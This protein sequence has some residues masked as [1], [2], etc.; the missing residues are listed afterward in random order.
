MEAITSSTKGHK[1]QDKDVSSVCPPKSKVNSVRK[2]KSVLISKFPDKTALFKTEGT[3]R[4]NDMEMDTQNCSG[5]NGKGT[6]DGGSDDSDD[7]SQ[8]SPIKLGGKDTKNTDDCSQDHMSEIKYAGTETSGNDDLSLYRAIELEDGRDN[9]DDFSQYSAIELEDEVTDTSSDESDDLLHYKAIEL[10][11][12]ST[13]TTGGGGIDDDD[14]I[15][16]FSQFRAIELEDDI[17]ETGDEDDDLS[18]YKPIELEDKVT[19]R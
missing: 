1:V 9:D 8:Y 4:D 18:H 10:E 6:D 2:Q 13:K 12:N 17:S 7:L 3:G 19:K 11:G 15:D 5:C 14:E 16:S